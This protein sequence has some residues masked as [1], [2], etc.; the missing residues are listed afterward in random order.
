M[1]MIF[2]FY[3]SKNKLV[4]RTL[5]Q[6]RAGRSHATLAPKNRTQYVMHIMHV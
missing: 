3:I 4:D 5:Q 2:I 1:W 6:K